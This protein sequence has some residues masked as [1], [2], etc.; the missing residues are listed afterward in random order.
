MMMM[1]LSGITW[2]SSDAAGLSAQVRGS[3]PLLQ[4]IP[5]AARRAAAFGVITFIALRVRSAEL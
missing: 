3:T 1:Q 5:R 4:I 2:R